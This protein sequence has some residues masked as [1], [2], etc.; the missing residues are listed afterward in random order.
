MS[1]AIENEDLEEL[2]LSMPAPR[3]GG[4]STT[5]TV[6]FQQS[7]EPV[8]PAP[9]VE[10]NKARDSKAS[11]RLGQYT[12]VK[13]LGEGSFGKVKL[14]THQ[15][16]GQKVAL[17]II[18]RKRL[19]TRDMAGRIEREIQYLQLLR[20]PHIIKLYTVITTPTEI[21]MVLEYAGGELFDYIVNNGRLQED[22]ARKFFQQIV[23]AVEYCHRHK[24]VHRDLKPENLLLDDQYNVKIAD[25]GLSNIMTDGNF[26]K[27]SCGSPNYAAPEVI[28]GKLYAGPEVDVWSCGVILYVLLV[29]RLPFDDEYIPTLFKKIAAGNYSIPNYLSPGAVSLIKKML[30][31]N[32][33]HRI[34]IGEIRMDPWFTKDLPAYLEPPIQEFFDTGID[35]NKAI[36]PKAV[37][38]SQPAPVVQKLHETVVSKLGKT[39]GYAKHDVQEALARDE[40]SAIKD[41]YLIVRENQIMKANPLLTNEQNLQPFLVSSPPTGPDYLSQSIPQVM[42]GGSRPQIIPPPSADHERARQG[43]NASSQL[44]NARSPVST[45]AILPSSLTEYHTAYMKG[46]PRP[47]PAS[48]GQDGSPSGQ[49]EEQRAANARRLKPNFRTLPDPQRPRP[50]PMTA[51]PAKKARP[52]KWQFGIRSRNQPAEAMLAIFKALKAM[53]AD[54]EIPEPRKTGEQSGSRSRSASRGSHNASGSRSRT[55]SQSSSISSHSS[56]GAVHSDDEHSPYRKPLTVRNTDTDEPR[57]RTKRHYNHTNDWGYRVPEDPWV[58]NARFR[59]DGM[60]PPGV[61]HPSSTHSSRVDLHAHPEA[62]RRS[63]TT[64]STGSHAVDG[65]AGKSSDDDPYPEPDEAVWIYMSIQLYSIDRD[66]F[67]VDFKCAGYE[68]LVSNLVREIKANPSVSTD[69][70]FSSSHRSKHQH[71]DGWDDEQGVWRRLDDG[72]P[73]PE[74]VKSELKGG[75]GV[76]RERTEEIGAGRME[77]EKVCTSPFPFLDVASTLILQLSG[78]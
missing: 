37:A 9:A 1:A 30:M 54:W 72:E 71:E 27:T 28:S 78:E 33:V 41:A 59:K 75:R 22:K 42:A 47:P 29:G 17:K 10:P 43:S 48:Q 68:R 6:D 64:T 65:G 76:L 56:E 58:I 18:N 20:H 63:S 21:I 45:I 67:V 16:S 35:P 25:F 39:M 34:T 38:P 5:K 11:Q 57:G 66:F 32:P 7:T 8:L 40:P 55:H 46:H 19:V 44:A 3:R 26:L 15:V 2:S 23:C 73:L 13:T 69:A 62:R 61:A 14:A 36:D 24:I 50:E 31:V 51:L 60:F 12:I 77:G 74:D 53:G 49:T 70:D 52:T 4:A